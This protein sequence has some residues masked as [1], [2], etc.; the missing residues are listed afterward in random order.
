MAR[1][2]WLV[3]WLRPEIASLRVFC[4]LQVNKCR[5]F[6]NEITSSINLNLINSW[7]LGFNSQCRVISLIIILRWQLTFTSEPK[8]I[9]LDSIWQWLAAIQLRVPSNNKV[10]LTKLISLSMELRITTSNRCLQILWWK[11]RCVQSTTTPN[12]IN[13]NS[14]NRVDERHTMLAFLCN[15]KLCLP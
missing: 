12:P 6:K 5:A 2:R 7:L 11:I 8:V 10:L 3:I 14:F 13:I 9:R 4:Q 15:L 1:I